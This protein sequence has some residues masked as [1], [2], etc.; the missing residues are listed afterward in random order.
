[1]RLFWKL[2]L[3]QLLAVSAVLAGVLAT[4]RA[5]SVRGIAVVVMVRER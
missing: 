1:M 4:T 3:L 5:F 2:F